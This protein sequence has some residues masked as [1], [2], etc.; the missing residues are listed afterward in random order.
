M[1][2]SAS[3]TVNAPATSSLV[4]TPIRNVNLNNYLLYNPTTF[5]IGYSTAAYPAT[6]GEVFNT[7][8]VTDAVTTA[9][10]QISLGVSEQTGGL[11]KGTTLVSNGTDF[12]SVTFGV[13]YAAVNKG[14]VYTLD[15]NSQPDNIT[16]A[17]SAGTLTNTFSI[18]SIAAGSFSISINANTSLATPTINVRF[19]IIDYNSRTITNL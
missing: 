19:S 4:I 14:G 7:K 9:F 5:E 6:T 12:Q 10:V 17:L 8:T 18:A 2:A 1:N 16:S 3:T 13:L 11:I 15:I